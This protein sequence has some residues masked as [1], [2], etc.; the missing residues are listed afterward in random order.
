[1]E[2]WKKDAENNVGDK[3]EIRQEHYSIG[4]ESGGRGYYDRNKQIGGHKAWWDDDII[5]LP[6]TFH[7]ASYG[8]DWSSS[9][10]SPFAALTGH[11]AAIKE[12]ARL[13]DDRVELDEYMKDA[14]NYR[15]QFIANRLKKKYEIAITYFQP[16]EKR[17]EAPTLLLSVQLK[18]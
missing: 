15:L 4:Y 13:T 7:T 1:M 18:K 16:D 5:H 3:K 6:R 9:S 10:V 14:L 11:D 12:T 8:G 17:M 2:R